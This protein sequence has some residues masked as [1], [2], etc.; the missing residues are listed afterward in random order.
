MTDGILCVP[1][2]GIAVYTQESGTCHQSLQSRHGHCDDDS[3]DENTHKNQSVKQSIRKKKRKRKQSVKRNT[4]EGQE[5]DL[6]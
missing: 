2:V 5:L 4:E 1:R 6:E 3:N